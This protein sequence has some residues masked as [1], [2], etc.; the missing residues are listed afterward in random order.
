MIDWQQ[1]ADLSNIGAISGRE[2][3]IVDYVKQHLPFCRY[4]QDRLGSGLFSLGQGELSL[5]V[6]THMDEIGFIVS[7]ID[8]TGYL[9][10]QPVG[11]VWTHTLLQQRVYVQTVKGQRYLAIIGGPA[12]HSLTPSERL[13]TVVPP[14]QLYLD[15]GVESRT[16]VQA[17]G[18]QVGDQ[19][20]L[21][22]EFAE[23]NNRDYVVGKAFD[24]RIS[25]AIGMAL[26]RSL[27]TQALTKQVTLATTVQEEVGIRG[28]RTSTSLLQ[29]DV[30]FALDTAVAGD[31][32]ANR[33]SLK[34]GGG[35]ALNVIDSMTVTHRGL[36]RFLEQLC[37]KYQ[38][39]YQYS[40]FV[41]GG[42]DAGNIHKI[43]TGVLATTLSIPI[44]YMHTHQSIIHK[45]D[46]AATLRLLQMAIEE[47]TP[48]VYQMILEQN[49]RFTLK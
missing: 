4:R 49:Y 30:A 31:T 18:I 43:G 5:M 41:D 20:T 9:R 46:V 8:A 40:C 44:R 42:T 21:A 37:E 12:V 3:A 45:Q 2:A 34:L 22:T 7:E 11:S 24:N 29:P 19:V 15:L 10:I 47:M 35:V 13:T 33:N 48:E 23:L 17:L 6:A 1:V 38:I 36:L 16:E 27:Q 14:E 39:P 26:M 28:A 32:P 25:V